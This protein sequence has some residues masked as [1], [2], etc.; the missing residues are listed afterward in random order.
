MS[1]IINLDKS[2]VARGGV[3]ILL[4]MVLL[5]FIQ[6]IVAII[7]ARILV[8]EDFGIFILITTLITFFRTS[9]NLGFDSA[10]IQEDNIHSSLNT[11]WTMEIIK[12]IILFLIMLLVAP[13]ISDFYNKF[14]LNNLIIATS[15]SFIL[16]GF[17]NIGVVYFRKELDFK[18][19]FILEIIPGVINSVCI[20]IL[21]IVLRNIWALIYSIIINAGVI[22][23]VSFIIHPY[24]PRFEFSIKK[25][26]T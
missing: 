14:E 21:V 11:V 9:T 4:G 1:Q 15:T 8:P 3:W 19:Q 6:V 16:L 18:K 13:L 5:R 7:T 2:R 10:L 24:R 12:G 20:V 17:K 23:L 25:F 26:K 22:L